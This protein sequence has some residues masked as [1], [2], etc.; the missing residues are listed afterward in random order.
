[1]PAD[2]LAIFRSILEEVFR[3]A[4]TRP[5]FANML[6]MVVGWILTTTPLRA[7]TES[8]VITGV[9]GRRHHEAFH[10]LFSRGT[11]SP[12]E[13]GYFLLRR[14]EPLI[15]PGSLRVVIDDTLAPKKGPHVFGLGTHLDAVRSTRKHRIFAFGHCWVMLAVLVRLPF[16][17]RTWALPLLFRLYRNVKDHER[18]GT[19]YRKKTELGREM[20]DAVCR[21]FGGTIEVCADSAYGNDTVMHSLPERVVFFGAMR[22]DAVLTKAPTSCA[23]TGRPRKRG[24]GLPKPEQ[25]ARDTATP[26]Q[27]VKAHLY[28]KVVDV[29]YKELCAQW[30]RAC[31]TRLLRI[32]VVATPNGSVPIRVFF[33]TDP[34]RDVR[35]IVESYACRWAIEVCF[36]DL[37]QLFGFADSTARARAAVLRM[38]PFVGLLY[39]VLVIWFAEGA[40]KSPLASPPL[41]PWYQH[42][43]DLS[44][45]DIL[46]AACRMLRG[47]DVLDPA[48]DFMNLGKSP[49]RHEKA[50]GSELQTHLQS[51]A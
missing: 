24:D 20:L 29:R 32:V 47:A 11:W 16:S 31:G 35:T 49:P 22:P 45:T 12:D 50:A 19:P 37:K 38:A 25:L 46:R 1:M 30:Y 14:L 33:C 27:S 28:G 40:W 8:L 2:L 36:R 17:R 13:L 6:V 39:S 15:G 18:E 43:R 42:K 7:V 48:S 41:R 44:F 3:P 23:K 10:R 51:A 9:A 34:T 26:W 5:A 21:W 4:L